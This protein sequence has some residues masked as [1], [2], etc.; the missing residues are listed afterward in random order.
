MIVIMIT[1]LRRKKPCMGRD[2][3]RN[4]DIL[5]NDLYIK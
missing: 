2:L 4:K 5:E 3:I 1:F